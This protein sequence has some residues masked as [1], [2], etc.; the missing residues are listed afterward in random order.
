MDD[1]IDLEGVDGQ[2]EQDKY[3][4]HDQ[5]HFSGANVAFGAFLTAHTA[6]Q[7]AHHHVLSGDAVRFGVERPVG[8]ISFDGARFQV[9]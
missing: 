3:C 8:G 4:R 5:Q 2:V 9:G 7:Q 6:T 1:G